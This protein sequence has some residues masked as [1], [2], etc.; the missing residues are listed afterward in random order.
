MSLGGHH[1]G[2]RQLFLHW[3]GVCRDRAERHGDTEL[4]QATIRVILGGIVILYM[5]SSNVDVAHPSASLTISWVASIFFPASLLLLV[6]VFR[7]NGPSPIRRYIGIFLDLSATSIA[8]AV[9]GEAGAPLLGIYLWVILGNGFRYGIHYLAVATVVSLIGFSGGALYSDYW[10]HHLLVSASYL[11]VLL[12]I[13]A[14]VA[15]LLEKLRKAIRRA[16]EASAAKS[17]FLAKMSHELRTPLNGVIGMSDLLIDSDLGS[18]EREFVKTIHNSGTTLLG[19]IDNILD[20][21]KI[22]AGR[23]PIEEVEFDVHRL[24]AESVAMFMPQAQ[25]KG[26][27]LTNWFDPRMP[28]VLRGD[29]LHIRQVLLN[30][31]GNAIKFTETGSVEVRVMTAAG[32]D[33]DDH[34]TLRFE[35][36]DTGIGI[37]AEDQARIFESFRQANTDTARRFGGTGLGTAI[38]RELVTLMN[39]RI[40]CHSAVGRGSLFWFELPLGLVSLSTYDSD[41][42]LA[43]ERVLVLGTGHRGEVLVEMLMAMGLR[44]Q[45]TASATEA[46]A[47]TARAADSD[48]P[49]RLLLVLERDFAADS[50]PI[51]ATM[52]AANVDMLRFLLVAHAPGQGMPAGRSGFDGVLG[53]PLRRDELLNAVHAARSARA[54]PEN[55]VS[56]ADYYR[57][58]VP[59]ERARLHVLVAEDNDTNRRVLRAILERAGHR[60]TV[61]EHGESALDAIQDHGDSF[62]LMVLDKN[63][64]GRSGLD[65]FRAHRFM[66]PRVPIPTII[67]SADATQVAMQECLEAGV[68]AFLTKPV[69]SR[70]L[71]E[72]IARI[73]D[74]GRPR[75]IVHGAPPIKEGGLPADVVLVDDEKLQSLRRLGGDIDGF[76][77]ELVRGFQR[78]AERAILDIAAA[79]SSSEYPALRAAVHALEGSARELGALSLADVASQFRRL[80]PFELGSPRAEMLFEQLRDVLT[81]TLQLLTEPT[82]QSRDDLVP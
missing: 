81:S 18:Q 23:L 40:G 25:R 62:D 57:R 26:I 68:D 34:R 37:A 35:V 78:D 47:A 42:N 21:S 52:A 45:A 33:R 79:L 13:P 1:I 49:Y 41:R 20:F 27:A 58:L 17:Q 28:Y 9:A 24:V 10:Q 38:A 73:G 64:P 39:G 76:Y 75:Q 80:K 53:L 72:T 48:D 3:R 4:E 63:M 54:L 7:G 19:I 46:A 14:Y 66:N 74:R 51:I 69:E 82:A 36:Q 29:P 16:N 65:V 8:I 11:L 70:R 15:A 56:L 71:L 22:E 30:L 5:L 12:L 6:A 61:V 31:L 60:L 2:L 59:A 44:A 32:P 43:G 77:D 50:R 67:L 55:V